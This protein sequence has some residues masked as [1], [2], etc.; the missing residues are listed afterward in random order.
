M[1][2]QNNELLDVCQSDELGLPSG[3]RAK[4][5]GE[6]GEDA[7][8]RYLKRQGYHILA[9]HVDSRAR[10]TRY[11]RGRR[12]HDRVRRSQDAQLR[13]TPA[14]R[15][16]PS[17]N[18]KQQRMTQ[19]ALAY[20]KSHGLLEYSARFDVVAI[21][22]PEGVTP[23]DHRAHS[24]RLSRRRPRP[25]FQLNRPTGVLPV[26]ARCV[27]M[28]LVAIGPGATSFHG[29]TITR[30]VARTWPSTFSSP[31]ASL[32]LSAKGSPARRSACCSKSAACR[33]RMQKLD[34]YINVDPGTMSPYQ[35][36]EVYVLDDGSETDLDLGHYERFTQQPAH[37]R[38]ELHDRPD[39][40]VGDQQGAARRV[41]RQDGPGH[42]A[43]HQRNQERHRQAG[44]RPQRP[45]RRR[46]HRNRRH[47]RRHREPAVSGSDPPVRARRRQG[48]LP[49]HPPD[50][51]ALPE[52][53]QGAEDEA[54]AALGRPAPRRSVSSP[55]SSS[56]APS[57][58]SAATTARRSPCSATC[59]STP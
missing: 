23:A 47:G 50:A 38:L 26:A 33:V 28:K 16:R 31:A 12:P 42:S 43:H 19:A 10:R 34:P 58:R 39:L 17:T 37:P 25:V 14:T 4:S 1:T 49:L 40:P 3:F 32:A 11:H 7:A 54:D 35:H 46:D 30:K 27:R 20:L 57:I 24:R 59:R 52:G 45:G 55:T 29:S 15:P 22:W 41:P 6:R 53:G 44:R 8:A 2:T 13:P 21:T 36:G 5:L 51:R 18:A 56:A 48:E 9:R